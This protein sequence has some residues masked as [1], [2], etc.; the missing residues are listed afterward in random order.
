MLQ[1]I[2]SSDPTSSP[3]I[4]P[5]FFA[6]EY[7]QQ[8]ALDLLKFHQVLAAQPALKAVIT[9]QLAPALNATVADLLNYAKNSFSAGAH[10]TGTNAMAPK[11]LGG[12]VDTQLRVYGIS[13]LRVADCSIFPNQLA[14]HPQATVYALAEKVCFLNRLMR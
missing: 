7:D 4:E 12:V 3:I 14:V 10:V 13:G 1:H 2:N 5:N 11:S 6:A 8:L 9:Q